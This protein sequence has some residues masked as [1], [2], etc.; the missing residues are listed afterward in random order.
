MAGM[1]A[2]DARRHR[3]HAKILCVSLRQ[4][5]S[6]VARRAHRDGRIIHLRLTVMGAS[7][8]FA[9]TMAWYQDSPEV[10][11]RRVAAG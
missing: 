3:S 11:R 7:F 10:V 4:G 8:T 6:A 9:F 1:T 2:L 5:D